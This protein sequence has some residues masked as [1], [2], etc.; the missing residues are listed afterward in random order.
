VLF[1]V[2]KIR[3]GRRNE[4]GGEDDRSPGHKLNNYR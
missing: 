4:R 3:R 1:V 2:E